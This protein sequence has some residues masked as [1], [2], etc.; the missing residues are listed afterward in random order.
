[1]IVKLTEYLVS[2]KILRVWW[3]SKCQYVMQV[4]FAI[5]CICI[6]KIS[7][8]DHDCCA[9]RWSWS[10]TMMMVNIISFCHRGSAPDARSST[11]IITT[12]AVHVR[13]LVPMRGSV[14]AVQ[15]CIT[16]TCASVKRARRCDAD[17]VTTKTI[18]A[19]S[20]VLSAITTCSWLYAWIEEPVLLWWITDLSCTR[21]IL[22]PGVFYTPS[23]GL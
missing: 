12:A 3:L 1:M 11:S 5:D 10:Q 20:A 9:T 13:S 2:N 4:R 14:D 17:D 7:P 15:R 8:T 23:G 22:C 16:S 18:L 21:T 6:E 19:P